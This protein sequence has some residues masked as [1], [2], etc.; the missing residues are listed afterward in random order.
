[1]KFFEKNILKGLK[2][3]NPDAFEVLFKNYHKK[4]YN[5]ILTFIKDKY[6][7]ENI[8][9]DV[10]ISLWETRHRINIEDSFDKLIYRIARNK[11]LNSL[12]KSLNKMT[13]INSILHS[14][15]IYEYTTDLNIEHAELDYYFHKFIDEL[16]ERR[17]EIFLCRIKQGLT[18]KEIACK[19]NISENTVDT[20]IRHALNYIRENISKQFSIRTTFH[21]ENN[22]MKS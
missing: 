10:F 8:L 13:Y 18:Y 5:F 16:P 7:A 3:G 1:M 14:Q 15:T 2:Q 6:E 4:V 19:L 11:S 9:Q 12:R 20:Q 21:P 22:N 17:R